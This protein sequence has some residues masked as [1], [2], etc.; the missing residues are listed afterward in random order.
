MLGVPEAEAAGGK[1]D[2]E[3]V[4]KALSLK[5]ALED[6]K[7]NTDSL[8]GQKEK[9]KNLLILQYLMSNTNDLSNTNTNNRFQTLVVKNNNP[10]HVFIWIET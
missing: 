5:T 9:A 7:K 6:T 4:S 10:L 3:D 1:M 8:L 2:G